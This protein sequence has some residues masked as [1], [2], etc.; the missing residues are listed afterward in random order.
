MDEDFDA[1]FHCVVQKI[2]SSCN[3]YFFEEAGVVNQGIWRDRV[4]NH[5]DTIVFKAV[6]MSSLE[7]ML[8]TWYS[9]LV[10]SIRW[11]FVETSN[12]ITLVASP[13]SMRCL[14]TE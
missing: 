13:D 9:T 7:V 14:T 6:R 2:A 8:P 4:D 12:T 10:S 1:T 11:L 3:I 5:V